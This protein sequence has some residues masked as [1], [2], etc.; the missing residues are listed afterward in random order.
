MLHS[1][2]KTN[3]AHGLI[4]LVTLALK[5]SKGLITVHT[6]LIHELVWEPSIQPAEY[7][8]QLKMAEKEVNK[9]T[10]LK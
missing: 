8:M 3:V 7:G 1:G 10:S 5:I 9:L 6:L 2:M 4:F